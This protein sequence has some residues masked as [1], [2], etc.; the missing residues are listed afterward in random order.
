[1]AEFTRDIM[2]VDYV[3]VHPELPLGEAVK[4]FLPAAMEGRRRIFGIMVVDEEGVLKGMLSM[5]DIL[6]FLCPKHVGLW[7]Q[8]TDLEVSGLMD[9]ALGRMKRILVGDIM[10]H[11][12]V[13]VSPG[14]HLLAVVDLMIR[15][16][17]RRLPVVEEGKVVGIAFIS[18]VF[19]ALIA[20]LADRG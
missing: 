5:Y 2:S 19:N 1:M 15:R 9:R 10:T 13:T 7:G 12:V 4:L 11:E 14:T 17:I 20:R 6:L 18:D 8:M 3:S 16:H